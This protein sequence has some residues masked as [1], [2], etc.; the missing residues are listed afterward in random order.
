MDRSHPPDLMAATPLPYPRMYEDSIPSTQHCNGCTR[1][2][3]KEGYHIVL[4]YHLPMGR[5]MILIAQIC[6]EQLEMLSL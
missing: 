3:L 6:K 4:Y 2:H 5:W 1:M